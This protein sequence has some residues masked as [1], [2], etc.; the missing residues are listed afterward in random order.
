ML[1]PFSDYRKL[2]DEQLAELLRPSYALLSRV[3]PDYTEY[4]NQLPKDFCPPRRIPPPPPPRPSRG[5]SSSA[6]AKPLNP[7][8]ICK[9][10]KGEGEG[11]LVD[12]FLKE[13][14]DSA[15]KQILNAGQWSNEH[16]QWVPEYNQ[17]QLVKLG[18]KHG[19]IWVPPP[20]DE[21]AGGW[22]N[23]RHENR[24]AQKEEEAD[25]RR[26][27]EQQDSDFSHV[28]GNGGASSSQ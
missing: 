16:R 9:Q 14:K 4:D 22:K 19:P 13:Q 27:I 5:R 3:Q 1:P 10:D 20:V 7:G 26:A 21:R 2:S 23:T 17:H 24:K 8:P 18:I 15:L 6:H 25:L 11:V 28:M 12:D